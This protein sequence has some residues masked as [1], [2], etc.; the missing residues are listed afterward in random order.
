MRAWVRR[1]RVLTAVVA[2]LL[3]AGLLA[4]FF[5]HAYLVRYVNRKL[6]D[7]PGYKAHLED[8]GVHLWRGAYSIEGL[9]VLKREG[10][11][12]APFFQAKTIDISLQWKELLHRHIVAKIRVTDPEINFVSSKKDEVD[13]TKIS[14][15]WQDQVKALIPFR[16]NYVKIIN[17]SIHWLDPYSD[18]PMDIWL[19]Q[20]NIGAYN[21]TNSE[22]LSKTLASTIVGDALAMK[23]GKLHFEATADPYEDL[24]TFKAKLTL[25]ELSLPQLNSFFKKYAALEVHDGTFNVYSE[26]AGSKG[27]LSGYVKPLID[28]LDTIKLKDEKKSP[29]EV[30]KGTIV[31][32]LIR[33]LTNDPKDRLGARLQISGR[34][35]QPGVSLWIA[36]TSALRNAFIQAI[37]A[38]LDNA[39]NIKDRDKIEIKNLKKQK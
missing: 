7:I 27:E 16:L 10:K 6:N 26:M 22:R 21:L 14:A 38:Q 37:P 8:I 2:V 23:D 25:K 33:L 12:V 32:I 9:K 17:G 34:Y 4:H 13:Q 1:H 28:D 35:D 18:P 29:L 15:R 19:H 3:T 11:S 20:F 24:P 30:I 39:L 36:A 5:L 31:E